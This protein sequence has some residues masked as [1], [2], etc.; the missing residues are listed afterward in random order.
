[1]PTT[2][3][4]YVIR[5]LRVLIA[6]ERQDRLVNVRWIVESLGHEVI[7]PQIEVSDVGEFTRTEH[8]DVALVGLGESVQRQSASVACWSF[9]S[10]LGRFSDYRQS[11]GWRRN[12][13]E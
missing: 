10:Q 5:P 11:A 4:V 12:D 13:C 2:D 3:G 1:M 8:P 6:N 7:P 9:E